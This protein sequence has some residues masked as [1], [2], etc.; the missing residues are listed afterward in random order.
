MQLPTAPT[1]Q[2][3]TAI[4]TALHDDRLDRFLP[5]AA[6]GREDAF[7][8]YCWNCSICEAFYLP[9]HFAEIAV[10]NAINSHLIH[11]LGNEWFDNRALVGT[12]DARRQSDL[13][14]LLAD[15]RKKHGDK[16][17]CHHLV[18]ELS[19]GFWQHLLTKR[20][21]RIVWAT[22]IRTAFPNLPNAMD[23]QE[24][25]DRDNQEMAKPRLSS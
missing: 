20:F 6:G 15:E 11:R 24:V 1:E 4:L 22:G 18:S 23:R 10:R 5:A 19:F 21:G 2:Q 3:L 12:L 14:A 8:L 17:T 13:K 9:L 25:H 7:K 16:M